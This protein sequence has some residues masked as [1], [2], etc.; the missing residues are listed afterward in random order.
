VR[1]ALAMA[2]AAALAA[3]GAACARPQKLGAPVCSAA[4]RQESIPRLWELW[5]TLG[6]SDDRWDD[7]SHGTVNVGAA[8]LWGLDAERYHRL[9]I[10][11]AGQYGHFGD[12][13]HG[14]VNVEPS[15][16]Y[17]GAFV[18]DPI[19]TFYAVVMAGLQVPHPALRPRVGLGVE[20]LKAFLAEVTG[21]ALIAIDGQFQ[22]SRSQTV[23]PG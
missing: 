4:T 6:L 19:A 2:M 15:A 5:G 12:N 23:V 10:G 14:P 22:E 1:A 7:R 20:V 9:G 16:S 8:A 18:Q 21:D 13:A 11:V 17:R 3:A